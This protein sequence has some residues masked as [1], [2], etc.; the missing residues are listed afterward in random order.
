MPIGIIVGKHGVTFKRHANH[1]YILEMWQEAPLCLAAI[2]ALESPCIDQ[3]LSDG[4]DS[5]QGSAQDSDDSDPEDPTTE[6]TDNGISKPSE[7]FS[8]SKSKPINEDTLKMWHA[9]LGHLGRQNI[10]K[11]AKVSKGIDLTAPP[12]REPCEPCVVSIMKRLPHTRRIKP[13]RWQNDLI[14]SDLQGPFQ[15]TY[16]GYQYLVTFLD[17]NTLRSAIFLLRDKSAK[18]VL[19]AFCMYANQAEHDDCTITRL[20]SGCGTKYDNSLMLEYRLSKG[21]TWEP[22][23]PGTPQVNGRSERLGQTLQK[24]ASAVLKDSRL[25]EKLWGELVL[26]ANYLRNDQPVAGRDTTPYKAAT[27]KPPRLSHL[28]LVFSLLKLYTP[29]QVNV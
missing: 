4:Q 13:G 14:H 28:R 21:I 17:D 10:L 19:D 20:W 26:T 7:S 25:S 24:M 29:A 9:R 8:N 2:N 5:A 11:F 12:P 15:P 18:S 6:V 16:D 1:L 3:F 23:M 22:T 27:G